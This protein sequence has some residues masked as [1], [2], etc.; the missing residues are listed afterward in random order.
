MSG[1]TERPLTRSIGSRRYEQF[2]ASSDELIISVSN[3]TWKTEGKLK[4]WFLS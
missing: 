2:A 4:S 1:S 3:Y